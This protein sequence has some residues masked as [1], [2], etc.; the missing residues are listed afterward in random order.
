MQM[1]TDSEIK[2]LNK[3]EL[4]KYIKDLQE[5]YVD[6]ENRYNDLDDCYAELEDNNSDLL[7][8]I[9]E[10]EYSQLDS[11]TMILDIELFKETTRLYG[12]YSEDLFNFIDDYM[13][14]YNKE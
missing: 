6:L 14:L 1:L 2:K 12:L 10:L 7:D 13:R 5:E 3:S 4:Q 9:E 11:E 8:Q